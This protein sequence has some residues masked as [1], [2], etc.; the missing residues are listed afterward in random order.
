MQK[1]KRKEN[2][3]NSHFLVLELKFYVLDQT[4]IK[5]LRTYSPFIFEIVPLNQ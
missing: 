3:C 5:L 1:K 4:S 2:V